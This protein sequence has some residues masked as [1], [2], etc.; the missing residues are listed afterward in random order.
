MSTGQ[1]PEDE[2][3]EKQRPGARDVESYVTGADDVLPVRPAYEDNPFAVASEDGQG[4]RDIDLDTEQ[5]IVDPASPDSARRRRPTG[6]PLVDSDG[7]GE[8]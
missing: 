1:R 6:G 8:P 4:D 7:G 3:N 5:T 2:E